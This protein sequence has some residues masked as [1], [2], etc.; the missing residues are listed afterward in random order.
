MRT[1]LMSGLR[2]QF[3]KEVDRSVRD[4]MDAVAPYTRFVRAESG[5]LSSID[6][7]LEEIGVHLAEIRND[8]ERAA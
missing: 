3:Q 4:V 6:S 8:V 2:G 7:E 5:K 1:D